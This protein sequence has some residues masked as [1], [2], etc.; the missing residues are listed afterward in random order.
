[1]CRG[2]VGGV[3]GGCGVCVG[4]VKGVCTPRLEKDKVGDRVRKRKAEH[5]EREAAAFAAPADAVAIG[6]RKTMNQTFLGIT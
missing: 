4:G 3:L 1:M 6:S 2:G 5:G